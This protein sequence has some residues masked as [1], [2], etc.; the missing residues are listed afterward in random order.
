MK[1]ILAILIVLTAFAIYAQVQFFPNQ[2]TSSVSGGGGFVG[3]VS[4]NVAS[5]GLLAVDATKTNGIAATLAHMTNALGLTGAPTTFLSSA[6]TQLTPAGSPAPTNTLTGNITANVVLIGSNSTNPVGG[7]I[8]ISAATNVA[9]AGTLTANSGTISNNLTAGSLTTTGNLIGTNFAN[10]VSYGAI[11]DGATAADAAFTSAIATGRP[12]YVPSGAFLVASTITLG[13]GA[14]IFGDGGAKSLIRSSNSIPLITVNGTNITIAGMGFWGTSGTAYPGVTGVKIVG[15][16]LTGTLI[17]DCYFTLLG[18]GIYCTNVAGNS[19]NPTLISNPRIDNCAYGINVE[20]GGEYVNVV[21]P[22]IYNCTGGLRIGSGNF[23]CVGG[24]ISD[25]DNGVVI[26]TGQN[27]AHGRVTGMLINHNITPVNI[28]SMLNGFQFASCNMY[29]GTNLISGKGAHFDNCTMDLDNTIY[30]APT[31][32]VYFNTKLPNAFANAKT[33]SGTCQVLNINDQLLD[34]TG[35]SASLAVNGTTVATLDSGGLTT[36]TNGFSGSRS[37]LLA[38]TAITFP[39]TTA[40]WTNPLP[41]SIM[42]YIDNTAVT[43]TA[44]KKNG[45]TIFS[46]LSADVTLGLQVG[47]YFSETYTVNTPTATYHPFP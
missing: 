24:S 36:S 17:K 35:K 16:T 8:L 20:N 19:H 18:S 47:E 37:N 2:S 39:A 7:P 28:I 14:S 13:N 41:V 11:P 27:D 22:E 12:V 3:A 33:F 25:S 40:N 38:S 10:I 44:V 6:G 1:K 26:V 31:N 15:L 29:R 23:N 21:N 30:N 45:A 46:G 42:V 43:G 5:S 4:N 9:I 32:C 34:G